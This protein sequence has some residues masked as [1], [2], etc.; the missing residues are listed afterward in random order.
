MRSFT[1]F[2]HLS[3]PAHML[4]ICCLF[5][6]LSR[7]TS[8]PTFERPLKVAYLHY[9]LQLGGVE[10]H[11][12]NILKSIDQTRIEAHVM[13]IRSNT[14]YEILND[15]SPYAEVSYFPASHLLKNGSVVR[16]FEGFNSLVA[17]LNK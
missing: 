11:L 17:Y 6:N 3:L 10:R 12:L 13:M 15:I 7:I 14:S 8:L 1:S 4:I 5:I 9:T 16:D 2:I